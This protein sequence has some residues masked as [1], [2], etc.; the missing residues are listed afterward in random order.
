MIYFEHNSENR[1]DIPEISLNTRENL[2]QYTGDVVEHREISRYT[3]N[4]AEQTGK[5][6]RYTGDIVEH[7]G[8]PE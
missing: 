2:S 4:I 7:T 1:V 3:G 5:Y 8:K 6:R